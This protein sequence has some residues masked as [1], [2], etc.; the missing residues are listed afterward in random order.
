MRRI[1]TMIGLSLVAAAPDA[2]MAQTY[3][4]ATPQPVQPVPVQPVPVPVQPVP[5]PVP[6]YPGTT[7]APMVSP[8][9]AVGQSR[10][11][12]RRSGRRAGRRH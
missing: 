11:V 9:G 3:Y 1:F 7:V 2:A 4:E 8:Y 10:R 12:G 5:V 6:A